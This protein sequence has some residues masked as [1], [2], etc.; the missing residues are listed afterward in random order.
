MKARVI[1]EKSKLIKKA[2]P[3][4]FVRRFKAFGWLVC[5]N[6]KGRE[7]LANGGNLIMER[8]VG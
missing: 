5:T 1:T 7:K 8:Y 4:R 3:R 6:L 2:V